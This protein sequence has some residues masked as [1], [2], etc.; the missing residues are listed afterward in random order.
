[1]GRTGPGSY[2]MET[3]EEIK[4]TITGDEPNSEKFRFHLPM[5]LDNPDPVHYD[6]VAQEIILSMD[7]WRAIFTPVLDEIKEFISKKFSDSRGFCKVR[8]QSKLKRN[9]LT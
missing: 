2:L 4:M 8:S 9:R 3:F 1:M 7:D 5:E 6:D